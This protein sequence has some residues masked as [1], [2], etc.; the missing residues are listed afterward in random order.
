[1]CKDYQQW[2]ELDERLMKILPE[3]LSPFGIEKLQMGTADL[4]K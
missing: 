2:P 4:R 1:M 3:D